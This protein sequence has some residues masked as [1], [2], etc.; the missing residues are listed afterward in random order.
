MAIKLE[1]NQQNMIQESNILK[2]INDK[3]EINDKLTTRIVPYFYERATIVDPT[4]KQFLAMEYLPQSLKEFY[5]EQKGKKGGLSFCQIALKVFECINGFHDQE[6]IHRDIKPDNFRVKDGQIFLIDLGA[7]KKYIEYGVHIPEMGDRDIVGNHLF[8][9]INVQSRIQAS[10]R[11]DFISAFYV[12][13]WLIYDGDIYW[14][15]E[16]QESGY[17]SHNQISQMIELKNSVQESL[18]ESNPDLKK[19]QQILAHL[20]GLRFN[21]RPNLQKIQNIL[22][23]QQSLTHQKINLNNLAIYT[24]FSLMV[25]VRILESDLQNKEKEHKQQIQDIEHNF[26]SLQNQATQFQDQIGHLTQEND[27]LKQENKEL[28]RDISN[29]RETIDTLLNQQKETLNPDKEK[30]KFSMSHHSSTHDTLMEEV[31]RDHNLHQQE[32]PSDIVFSKLEKSQQE[33]IF[34]RINEDQKSML[35]YFEKLII[36]QYQ[37]QQKLLEKQYDYKIKE[38]IWKNQQNHDDHRH[39]KKLIKLDLSISPEVY[40]EIL[41]KE[42]EVS[43]IFVKNGEDQPAQQ[44]ILIDKSKKIFTYRTSDQNTQ[45]QNTEQSYFFELYTYRISSRKNERFDEKRYFIQKSDSK[46]DIKLYRF[47]EHVYNLFN[48]DH[49]YD[50]DYV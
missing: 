15:T 49:D 6:Y 25:Q 29:Q 14:D 36:S 10:T 31:K 3:Y 44:M 17:M 37:Y 38:D 4:Y 20:N 21:E 26:I 35:T 45:E 48:L 8:A 1:E 28:L 46:R 7:S 24:P 41:G 18:D 43:V 19:M 11:D 47:R 9:S 33:D 13:Y 16:V 5:D 22:F 12:L 23:E 39:I 34:R 40:R 50:Y 27:K 32:F 30:S 2:E 42:L